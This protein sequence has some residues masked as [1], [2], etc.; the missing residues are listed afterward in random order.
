MNFEYRSFP[1]TTYFGYGKISILPDLLKDYKKAMVFAGEIMENYVNDLIATLGQDRIS[2]FSNIVQHVPETLV[3]EAQTRLNEVNPDVLISIGGGSSLG[4]AKALALECKLPIIAVP[5]TFAGSEQTNIWG[6]TTQDG[7]TT[8]RSDWVL[9]KVVI[10]D[11]NMTINMPLQ[12]AVTSAMN[13]MAHLMEAIYSPSG[14]PITRYNALLGMKELK[15]GLEGVAKSKTL[16]REANEKILFG[17]YLAG[18]SLCEV[19]MSLHHKTAHVLGGSFGMDHAKVHTVLQP[20]VLAYQWP[21]LS[22]LMQKDFIN[23]LENNYPPKALRALASA[24]GANTDLESIGFNRTD[25]E[26]SARIIV[27]KPYENIGPI[28]E[29]GM[30]EMLTNAYEGRLKDE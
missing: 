22:E 29:T 17:A 9:P 12:L 24:A 10:Y 2:Q 4:L 27:S 19:A 25:I 23:V 6:I 30:I 26:K 13:A 7:K 16:T 18:K 14:N 15:N 3:H 5:T 1:N 21:Y 11:P 28:T 20:Y 8:G